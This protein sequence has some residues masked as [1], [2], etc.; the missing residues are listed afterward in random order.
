MQEWYESPSCRVPVSILVN[1]KS[2]MSD[3]KFDCDSAEVTKYLEGAGGSFPKV[4]AVAD[5]STSY[6][7]FTVHPGKKYRFRIRK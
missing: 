3:Q 1:G 4:P 6:E 5:V 2:R 7:Q